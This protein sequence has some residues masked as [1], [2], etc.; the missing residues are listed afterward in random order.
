MSMTTCHTHHKLCP[1]QSHCP[2][3]QAHAPGLHGG[4]PGLSSFCPTSR[5][6]NLPFVYL[7]CNISWKH[8]CNKFMIYDKAYFGF[9]I[10][11]YTYTC[12]LITCA[13]LKVLDDLFFFTVLCL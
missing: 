3:P 2:H 5:I 8:Q 7:K 12:F 1:D 10:R 11:K 13:L 9:H 4:S 6:Q